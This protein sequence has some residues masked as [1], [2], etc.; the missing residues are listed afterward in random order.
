MRRRSSVLTACSLACN[1]FRMV[2]RNT[3]NLFL[4]RSPADMRE[5]EKSKGFRL[6]ETSP[7]AVFS[8][9]GAE[10]HEPGL[11]RVQLQLELRHSFGEFFPELLGF[12]SKLESQHDVIGKAHAMTSPRARFFRHAWTH[13]SKT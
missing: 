4:A 1:R 12:P 10:L 7:L 13:R 6:P 9:E 11:I 5:T 2:C 3:V 8:R